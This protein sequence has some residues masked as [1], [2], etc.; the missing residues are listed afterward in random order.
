MLLFRLLTTGV[1]VA[2]VVMLATLQP[3]YVEVTRPT[4][5][6]DRVPPI[7][8]IDVAG[9]VAPGMLASLVH[10]RPTEWVSAIN[11]R[12]LDSDLEA[13][14]L[15]ASLAPYPGGFLDLTVSSATAERRVLVLMH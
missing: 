9:S 13:G 7:S 14:A 11:D 12:A 4:V 10:L 3:V 5:I 2:C 15:I 6:H 1:C 8:V